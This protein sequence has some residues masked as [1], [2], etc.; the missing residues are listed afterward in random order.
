MP[1]SLFRRI[2]FGVGF[3]SKKRKCFL[4]ALAMPLVRIVRLRVDIVRSRNLRLSLRS[5]KLDVRLAIV[6][7]DNRRRL[8]QIMPPMIPQLGVKAKFHVETA[9]IPNRAVAG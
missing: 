4:D 5:Q 3:A 9:E 2:V 7:P 6:S 1:R 8:C